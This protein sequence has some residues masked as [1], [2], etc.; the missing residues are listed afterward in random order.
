MS[1][2]IIRKGRKFLEYDICIGSGGHGHATKVRFGARDRWVGDD[3][4]Y[5]VR[6]YEP[7]R[8]ARAFL[9][10]S[11]L[12]HHK[13]TD[14]LRYQVVRAVVLQ[15]IGHPTAAKHLLQTWQDNHSIKE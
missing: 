9:L 12:E 11:R 13:Q 5:F 15:E 7:S 3:Y 6:E 10:M 14:T 4:W 8:Q 2:R 1:N